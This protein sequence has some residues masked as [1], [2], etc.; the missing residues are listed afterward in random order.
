MFLICVKLLPAWA[1]LQH[2][3][4]TAVVESQRA[5]LP[6]RGNNLAAFNLP[7]T[8]SSHSLLYQKHSHTHT[9]KIKKNV[10]GQTQVRGCHVRTLSAHTHCLSLFPSCS[11]RTHATQQDNTNPITCWYSLNHYQEQFRQIVSLQ[12][13][14]ITLP[15]SEE[16][17]DH[18]WW[19]KLN[20]NKAEK[21]KDQASIFH[22]FAHYSVMWWW[23]GDGNGQS[24]TER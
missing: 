12:A 18:D 9:H 20:M 22:H 3:A 21:T 4:F 5:K 17:T 13:K 2:G 16:Q 11:K 14:V 23:S 15:S 6:T 1:T 24:H 10:H 7:L 8:F 19:G